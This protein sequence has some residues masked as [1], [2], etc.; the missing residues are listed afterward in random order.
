MANRFEAGAELFGVFRQVR[1]SAVGYAVL[2]AAVSPV[3]VGTL[4]GTPIAS[5]PVLVGRTQVVADFQTVVSIGTVVAVTIRAGPLGFAGSILE[6]A[7]AS[8]YLLGG[9][10]ISYL[11][12]G[13]G[14][15]FVGGLTWNRSLRDTVVPSSVRS[16]VDEQLSGDDEEQSGVSSENR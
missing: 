6:F 2:L 9:T 7:G 12:V 4:H 15:V 10:G 1:P 14:L 11:V 13:F 3:L 5:E 8:S 16:F